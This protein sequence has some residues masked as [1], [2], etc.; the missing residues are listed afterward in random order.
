MN[1]VRLFGIL[2]YYNGMQAYNISFANNH[3][4]RMDVKLNEL[5]AC[6]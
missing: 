1:H 5:N 2:N 6:L 4:C 3:M